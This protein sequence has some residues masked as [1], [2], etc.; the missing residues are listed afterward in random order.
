MQFRQKIL[1]ISIDD[2]NWSILLKSIFLKLAQ[3]KWDI[4]TYRTTRI[5]TVITWGGGWGGGEG[6]IF[7]Y[8]K[9]INSNTYNGCL[10]NDKVMTRSE[11]VLLYSDICKGTW[12]KSPSITTQTDRSRVWCVSIAVIYETMLHIWPWS[13]LSGPLYLAMPTQSICRRNISPS[14]SSNRAQSSP[15]HGPT[16]N[17]CR[18]VLHLSAK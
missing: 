2:Q 14:D 1:N 4:C 5:N 6:K 11:T 16:S 15:R 10:L 13:Y 18:R 8:Q 17:R 9:Y 12:S 3:P 7:N